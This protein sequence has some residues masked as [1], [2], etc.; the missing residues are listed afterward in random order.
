[1]SRSHGDE[2][3]P[4]VD[5]GLDTPESAPPRQLSDRLERLPPG[6]PSSPYEA[7]GTRREAAPR[8]RDLDTYAYDDDIDF[9]EPWPAD[10]GSDA[11]RPD[12]S[13]PPLSD[14]EWV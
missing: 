10:Q 13:P 4:L 5:Q 1:M 11:D 14:A 2:L 8:L 6:H 9:V 3:S 7:D 12:D